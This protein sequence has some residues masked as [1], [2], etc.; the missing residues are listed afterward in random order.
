[1]KNVHIPL[2][3][4]FICTVLVAN[5]ITAMDSASATHCLRK[6][7]S[8]SSN[9]LHTNVKPQLT[10][11]DTMPPAP[12][13]NSP[14]RETFLEELRTAIF[15]KEV[16]KKTQIAMNFFLHCLAFHKQ[17]VIINL[18][19]QHITVQYPFDVRHAQLIEQNSNCI[20]PEN[21]SKFYELM[22]FINKRK[23][24]SHAIA[25]FSYTENC[26]PSSCSSQTSVAL[27]Q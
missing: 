7:K 26:H 13:Y 25:P 6:T 3:L 27:Y 5:T 21:V 20:H 24:L 8:A 15:T 9:L 19:S 22:S 16:T 11:C 23:G 10:R 17:R 18:G 12:S 1:M 4:T 2:L 14:V